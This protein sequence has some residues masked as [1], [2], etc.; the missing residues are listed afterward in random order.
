MALSD[1]RLDDEDSFR[2]IQ[3]LFKKRKQDLDEY[4]E[5]TARYGTITQA[6][7]TPPVRTTSFNTTAIH[8]VA[9]FHYTSIPLYITPHRKVYLL[10]GKLSI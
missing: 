6:K 9:D 4:A 8:T 3:K 5:L 1:V 7:K 10:S 2:N